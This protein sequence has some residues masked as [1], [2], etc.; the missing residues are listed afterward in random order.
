MIRLRICW[1][2]GA[3]I[4]M[5]LGLCLVLAPMRA[6]RRGAGK[7]AA[8][9]RVVGLW[10]RGARALIRMRLHVEGAVPEG[11]VA[12]V[13]NHLSYIDIVALWCVV[14]GVFVARAD[15]ADWPLI[16]PVGRFIGTIFIERTRKRD[17]L[18]VIP[19]MEAPLAAG[20]SVIFFPEGTSS[21]GETVLPFRSSLFE[22]AA[23]Q[24][25]PVAG[26][27][28]KFRTHPPAVPADWSV[29]WWGDMDFTPH[30]L[31]LLALPAF[32]AHLRFAAPGVAVAPAARP[33]SAVRKALCREAHGAVLAAFEPTVTTPTDAPAAAPEP[34]TA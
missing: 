29:C 7:D 12:I 14:P 11:P 25:V 26:A 23:R 33:P 24:G 13:A 34:R 16:G 15:V 22:A 1:R 6:L 5:T 19:L 18:R 9:D 31:E 2:A 28:L 32:E 27:S 21:R 10:A 8:T 4:C 17:L 30:I 20:R 3:L